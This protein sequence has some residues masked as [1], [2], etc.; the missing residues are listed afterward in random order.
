MLKPLND[1]SWE[2]LRQDLIQALE[3]YNPEREDTSKEDENVSFLEQKHKYYYFNAIPLAII[4]G[5]MVTIIIL[6]LKLID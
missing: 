6:I 5:I 3:E 4:I 1:T 2:G